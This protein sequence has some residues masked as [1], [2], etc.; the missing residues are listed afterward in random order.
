MQQTE[1]ITIKKGHRYIFQEVSFSPNYPQLREF[2]ILEISNE[3]YK[4]KNMIGD[5]I[6]WIHQTEIKDELWGMK[7]YCVMEDLGLYKKIKL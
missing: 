7:G 6:F 3:H 1:T 4:V 2:L 5:A